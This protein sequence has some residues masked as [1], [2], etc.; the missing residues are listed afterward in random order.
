ME[1]PTE[2]QS[3]VSEDWKNPWEE[4]H[5]KPLPL[6]D[7]S[8]AKLL[9]RVVVLASAG[10]IVVVGQVILNSLHFDHLI[11][12]TILG[13]MYL[14]TAVLALLSLSFLVM[15][16]YRFIVRLLFESRVIHA[17]YTRSLLARR[18]N[19]RYETAAVSSMSWSSPRHRIAFADDDDRQ[20]R[21]EKQ[22]RQES[23]EE[24][25]KSRSW[26]RRR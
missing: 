12:L 22:R 8:G 26:V 20:K 6:V 7:V 25:N 4:F 10:L 2:R 3:P 13:I 11:Y 17:S 9:K 15:V 24:G 1:A 23:S 21:R 19:E 16:S 14:A 5:Y 18:E